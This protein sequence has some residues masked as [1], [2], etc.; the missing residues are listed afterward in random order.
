MYDVWQKNKKRSDFIQS[1]IQAKYPNMKLL[2]HGT[3]KSNAISI[4]N[5]TEIRKSNRDLAEEVCLNFNTTLADVFKDEANYGHFE[6]FVFAEHQGKSRDS[7]IYTSTGLD[8]ARIYAEIGP[9]WLD[10]LLRY[11]ACKHLNIECNFTS[12]DQRIE[13]WISKYKESPA[14]VIFDATKWEDYVAEDPILKPFSSGSA[15]V[16]SYPIPTEIVP[17]EFI[18]WIPLIIEDSN[19]KADEEI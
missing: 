8:Q 4:L 12:F 10:H 9:E 17:L 18:D 16:L 19:Q 2:F 3:S 5:L 7:T 13:D 1:E 6:N 11:F 15:V 14:I